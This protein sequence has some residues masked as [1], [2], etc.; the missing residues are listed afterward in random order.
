MFII[1]EAS[2]VP[3]DALRVIDDMLRDIIKIQMSHLGE[4]FSF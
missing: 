4:K 3:G 1:D 2:M